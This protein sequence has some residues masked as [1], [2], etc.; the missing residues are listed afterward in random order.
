MQTFQGQHICF[1]ALQ[2][3]QEGTEVTIS[4]IELAA[5]RAERRQQLMEQYYFD[6]DAHLV[7]DSSCNHSPLSC[8]SDQ[9]P[10]S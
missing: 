8:H 9:V 10:L 1:Q 6:I 3:I 2:P 4:Y 7:A 5:T